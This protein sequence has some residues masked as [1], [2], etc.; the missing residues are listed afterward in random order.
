MWIQS[1]IYLTE[2][3]TYR[4]EFMAKSSADDQTFAVVVEDGVYDKSL[5]SEFVADNQWKKYTYEFTAKTDEELV[6]KYFLGMVDVDCKLYL[7][8]VSITIAK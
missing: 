5:Y 1:G 2:G 3:E 8:D 4:I 6:L 7:D